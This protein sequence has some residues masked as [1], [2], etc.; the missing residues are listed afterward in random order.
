MEPFLCITLS[1]WLISKVI[2]SNNAVRPVIRQ[3]P[4][5]KVDKKADP[6][7]DWGEDDEEVGTKQP[8]IKA[9]KEAEAQHQRDIVDLRKQGYTDELIA[10]I[11]PTINNK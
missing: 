3:S 4:P 2:K 9:Q 10:V 1:L 7:A 8:D 6:F 5:Q 11:L